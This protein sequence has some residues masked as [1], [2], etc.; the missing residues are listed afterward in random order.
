MSLKVGAVEEDLLLVVKVV[1]EEALLV[2]AVNALFVQA[3]V[4]A[5]ILLLLLALHF[6]IKTLNY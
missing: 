2:H 1:F 5:H 6:I 4:V 3:R